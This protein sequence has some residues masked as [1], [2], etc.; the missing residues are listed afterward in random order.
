MSSYINPADAL[1]VTRA[2]IENPR[3]PSHSPFTWVL[4]KYTRNL[5]GNLNYGDLSIEELNQFAP[6]KPGLS[7]N[8]EK[9]IALLL[10]HACKEM[11][12]NEDSPLKGKDPVAALIDLHQKFTATTSPDYRMEVRDDRNDNYDPI[13]MIFCFDHNRP[14]SSDPSATLEIEPDSLSGL[15]NSRNAYW[16]N[17]E[18]IRL[19]QNIVSLHNHWEQ[20]P[21]NLR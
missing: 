5:I 8:R 7:T 21:P 18:A 4:L 2:A 6:T 17:K 11:V 20:T 12:T 9:G 14:D 1:S 10:G 16:E 3:H 13:E 19:A 15:L